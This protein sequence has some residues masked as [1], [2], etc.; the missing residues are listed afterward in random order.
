MKNDK[1][2]K[3]T[4]GYGGINLMKSQKKLIALIVILVISGII[5]ASITFVFFYKQG[6]VRINYPSK[7]KYPVRGVDVSGYQGKIDWEVLMKQ[8]IDFAFIKSTEGS[9]FV[10]STFEE[11]WKNAIETDLKVGAYHFFS[12]DSPGATQAELFCKTVPLLSEMLP[13][14]IDV[15]HYGDYI[16]KKKIDIPAVKRELR[17]LVD[18]LKKHY[19]K[20]PIIYCGPLYNSIIKDDFSDCD[21]WY[22]SVYFPITDKENLVFWQ[23]SD[24][25]ILDG[26]S[27]SEKFIDM[28]VFMG[29][30]EEFEEYGK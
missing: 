19:G 30:R 26:Y 15:E 13:P 18:A 12:F 25:H 5:S 10:S 4:N 23:Y 27:G 2:I 20:T 21:L 28:N 6:V 29:T 16:S 22:R 9:T 3:Q 24:N 11:N 1:N 8:G 14:V 7:E 17:V